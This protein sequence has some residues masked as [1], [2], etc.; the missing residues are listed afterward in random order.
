MS[1]ALPLPPRPN[2]DY[3]RS[4]AR[5]LCTAVHRGSVKDW[6]ARW[7]TNLAMLTGDEQALR[8]AGPSLAGGVVPSPAAPGPLG[9]PA[10]SDIAGW[11][12]RHWTKFVD[13]HLNK[14]AAPVRLT[15]AQFFIARMHGF[16]SWPIFASHLESLSRKG[17][18]VDVFERAV[19]AIVVGDAATLQ[20]L[21][22]A[23]PRLVRAR[24]TRDHR[25]TLLHYVAANGIE[26]FR[27]RTPANIVSIAEML[28]EAGA[29]VNATSEAYGGQSKTLGLAATSA[30]PAAAGVQIELLET[31]LR[32]G[33][34]LNEQRIVWGCLV[35][36]QGRAARFLASRGAPLDFFEAAGVGRLDVLATYTDEHGALKPEISE[37]ERRSAFLHACGYGQTDAVRF[38]L[39]R[40]VDAAIRG[41]QGDTG[42]HWATYGPHVD[43]TKLL[44]E[45]G[46]PIE[47]RDTTWNA[48]PL[49]W[50]IDTWAS[51]REPRARD[52][53]RQAAQL[54]V[55][56]GAKVNLDQFDPSIRD[57]VR[58]D[59]NMMTALGDPQSRHG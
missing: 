51:G 14:G 7:I 36:G 23:H 12:E 58:A 18:S 15:D 6:A 35:N 28:I 17:S 55:R 56:A 5:D 54:L 59:P 40:G 26:D 22:R 41:G 3:Y 16:A 50:T 53:A 9:W 46:A 20:T 52:R 10:G 2:L 32:H 27:Q 44:I 57:D 30:H 19:D 4:L 48:T 8:P 29:D 38:L 37:A 1:D 42:L 49:D 24:S 31:L 25:S 43:V 47:A 21:L 33:A 11:V 34:Q 13:A 39:D 45:R